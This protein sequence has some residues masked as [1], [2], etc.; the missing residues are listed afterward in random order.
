[1]AFRRTFLLI[2]ILTSLLQLDP[3]SHSEQQRDARDLQD[4]VQTVQTLINTLRDTSVSSE[5]AQDA[6]Q[7]LLEMWNAHAKEPD[8]AINRAIRNHEKLLEEILESDS[9]RRVRVRVALILYGIGTPEARAASSKNFERDVLE[10]NASYNARKIRE[11]APQ[12]REQVLAAVRLPTELDVETLSLSSVA[13]LLPDDEGF[14]V[15]IHENRSAQL[16]ELWFRQGDQYSL[17]RHVPVEDRTTASLGPRKLFKFG[18]R[19]FLMQPVLYSG[20]GLQ[21]EDHI[22][23]IDRAT[24][25]LQDVAFDFVPADL[26]LGPGEGPRRGPFVTYND[27]DIS[28]FFDVWGDGYSVGV[29]GKYAIDRRADGA[30]TMR[31]TQVVREPQTSR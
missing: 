27:D 5:S 17:L 20:T 10:R 24:H 2:I 11:T 28:F 26:K 30:W 13:N 1:M 31:A 18:G 23:Q 9:S 16:L 25:T 12:S 7:T 22:Y 3:Y 6:G 21:H 19:E 8:S 4:P 15:T 29:S 14:V